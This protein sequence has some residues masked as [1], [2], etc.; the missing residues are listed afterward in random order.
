MDDVTKT[1]TTYTETMVRLK[2]RVSTMEDRPQQDRAAHAIEAAIQDGSISVIQAGTGTGKANAA[3]IPAILSPGRV[4][5]ATATKALQSQLADKD[6]P[7]LREHMGVDFSHAILKGFGN[8]VCRQKLLEHPN[9]QLAL[10]VNQVLED[11]PGHTGEREYLPRMVDMDW[12][13]MTT[14][15]ED[16]PGR[17]ECAFG[18]NCF[19]Y[20]A[21]DRAANAKVVVTNHKLIA[22]DAMMIEAT[23]G[24]VSLLGDYSTLILDEGHELAE[25]V[26]STLEWRLAPGTLTAFAAQIRSFARQ[27]GFEADDL[28]DD[29]STQAVQFFSGLEEGR[30]RQ[31]D[32]AADFGRFE[33]LLGVW[34][35]TRSFLTSEEMLAYMDDQ[36]KRI[37]GRWKRLV[38]Q[39]E[40]QI[41]QITT[42]IMERDDVLVRWVESEF[43]PGGN[44][45]TVIK[46]QPVSVAPWC[47]EHL[48]S[49]ER[50]TVLLSATILVDGKSDF[51]AEQLG[52]PEHSVLDVGTPFDY[53]KQAMLYVPGNLADPT[54]DNGRWAGQ[55]G[56]E[57][58]EL[59][60]ASRGR[61]L[62]LFTSNA[63]MRKTYDQI[64]HRIDYPTDR[65]GG[66]RTNADLMEW[67][68]SETDSVLFATKSFFTGASFE[69]ETL[70]LLVIDKLPFPVPTEP[71]FQAKSE[72]IAKQTGD[73]W[74]SF[75]RLS[76]PMMTLPLQQGVGRLIRT[77][78]DSGV[79]ALMD[80]RLRT[81]GYGKIILRSLPGA[82]LTD[83]IDAVRS[84]FD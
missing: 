77:K 48:W 20:G 63:Q 54:K 58:L 8:Y 32:I 80:P 35:E 24:A 65:Q 33:M 25:Y 10:E 78:S 36:P 47:A 18:Q 38:R 53:G 6:I 23:D 81:K 55:M 75:N 42:L 16:C 11:D 2:E 60:K 79:M 69:G 45:R 5:Y 28:A 82:P 22:I 67:F 74:A 14:S 9:G 76:V 40:R 30:L 34:S 57:I 83:S 84:F 19:A 71:I 73:T 29:F 59:V 56:E 31:V 50:A 17:Q 43:V 62:L 41:R 51:I 4:V 52:L 13:R 12:A 21:R 61:A 37:T 1:P 70:S 15:T 46:T 3:L 39:A 68:R 72:L 7:F 64:A 66:G 27:H 44:S 49:A 26:A